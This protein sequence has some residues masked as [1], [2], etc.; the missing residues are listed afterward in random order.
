MIN[1]TLAGES[2][3]LAAVS[4]SPDHSRVHSLDGLRAVSAG[5]VVAA[6][7]GLEKIVPGGLGVTIFFFISGFII[8]RLLLSEKQRKGAINYSAFYRRRFWRLW[9]AIACAVLG[10]V[11]TGAM[12]G[13]MWA[14]FGDIVS[15]L[16]FFQN[17]WGVLY[18]NQNP[19][20]IHWSLAVE[21]H[22]YL[23]W[24]IVLLTLLM[25]PN[26]AVPVTVAGLFVFP[27]YRLW[28]V[29]AEV[30]GHISWR[31][32]E[33]WTYQLSHLRGDSLLFGCVLA[34]VAFDKRWRPFL[35]MLAHQRSVW[36]G[37]GLLLLTLLIRDEVFRVTI[38]YTVQGSALF[39]IFSGVLFA[40]QGGLIRQMLNIPIMVWLG[41]ISFSVY[42][43]HKTMWRLVDEITGM[44]DTWLNALLALGLTL[45]VAWLS[46]RLI[47][48][49]FMEFSRKRNKPSSIGKRN[50]QLGFYPGRPL[51]QSQSRPGVQDDK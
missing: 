28:L 24:P 36:I 38:R 8:T 17:Y 1:S 34:L 43:W 15:S 3:H 41:T 2:N 19:L 22:F 39:L 9:P 20:R 42:L 27:V 21:F 37:A 13:E 25:R 30:R 46:Y 50:S 7:Y 48:L 10:V 5:L 32:V 18:P 31:D 45:L 44:G 35:E 49:R 33:I 14:S 6:H 51:D 40:K 16:L 26:L 23:L 4:Y 11:L 12:F 29:A 47:E